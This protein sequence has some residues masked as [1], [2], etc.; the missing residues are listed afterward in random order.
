[1]TIKGLKVVSIAKSKKK[2][3]LWRIMIIHIF[4]KHGLEKG[5]DYPVCPIIVIMMN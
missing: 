4:R 5:R 2:R 1:M 3:K